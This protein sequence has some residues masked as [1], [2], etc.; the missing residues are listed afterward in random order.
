MP[1]IDALAR[2]MRALDHAANTAQYD[3]VRLVMRAHHTMGAL[4]LDAVER[5]ANLERNAEAW[6]ELCRTILRSA[7]QAGYI[8]MSAHDAAERH[9]GRMP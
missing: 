6:D 7:V 8:D 4:L 9:H 5:P 2:T 3:E 1:D